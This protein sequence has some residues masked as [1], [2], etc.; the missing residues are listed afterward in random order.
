MKGI[1][2]II[3][4]ILT[5]HYHHAGVL[6][7]DHLCW[8]TNVKEGA[9]KG[10]RVYDHEADN[11]VF[12]DRSTRK[13]Q[14]Y[15][16]GNYT[17]RNTNAKPISDYNDRNDYR[18]NQDYDTSAR[19]QHQQQQY[20]YG[21]GRDGLPLS[22][23]EAAA[24][25]KQQYNNSSDRYQDDNRDNYQDRYQEEAPRFRSQRQFQETMDSDAYT[26]SS[27]NNNN[28]RRDAGQYQS[29]AAGNY[30]LPFNVET[31]NGHV[32]VRKN[33]VATKQGTTIEMEGNSNRLRQSMSNISVL[34][35]RKEN[36]VPNMSEFRQRELQRNTRP[37]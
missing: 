9:Y 13:Q 34:D 18:R 15:D 5:Y 22:V 6:G 23:K 30:Q 12:G 25:F 1:I 17:N 24:A 29:E 28:N 26:G 11:T 14:I 33:P 31:V 21:S 27:N 4:I 37:W 36:P 32:I 35:D 2:I 3:I 16:D 8:K 7:C 20:Q 19:Q 10:Q